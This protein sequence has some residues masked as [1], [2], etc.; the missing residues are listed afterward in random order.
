MAEIINGKLVTAEVRK[1]TAA[2]IAKFKEEY[3]VTPGLAVILVGNDPASAVY[4]RNK[5]KGCLEV[6]TFC[7]IFLVVIRTLSIGRWRRMKNEK[8]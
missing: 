6:G 2:E 8:S 7:R 1:N 5:H 3:G 4:V